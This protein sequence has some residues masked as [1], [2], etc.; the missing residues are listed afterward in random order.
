[1]ITRRRYLRGFG[2][3]AVAGFLAGCS[4]SSSADEGN[5]DD[6]ADEEDDEPADVPAVATG[7]NEPPQA[8]FSW[9]YDSTVGGHNQGAII[10][11]HDGGEPLPADSVRISGRGFESIS[12]PG[13]DHNSN[14]SP[15]ETWKR[16]GANASATRDGTRLI[17]RGDSI[18]IAVNN[19][20]HLGVV[21]VAETD[22]TRTTLAEDM[23]PNTSSYDE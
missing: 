7:G 8:N 12:E 23:G 21:W 22:G 10:I 20:Y 17:E 5:D 13:L 1:M 9:N 16:M 15:N 4:N 2:T 3:L 19:A 11:T 18:T 14:S 6:E